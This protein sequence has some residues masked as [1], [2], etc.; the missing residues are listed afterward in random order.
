M[1]A[2]PH[3]TEGAESPVDP[4]GT[5][6]PGETAIFF[7]CL[8]VLTAASLWPLWT[9]RFLPMQDYPQ[10]L[11]LAHVTST[12]DH[13]SFNWKEFY[14]VDVGFRPYMLWY[15]AMDLLSKVLTAEIAGRILFSLYILLLALLA[16]FARRLAPKGFLPWGALLLFPF[17]FNQ[18]YYMGFSNYIISLPILFLALLDLD[19]LAENASACDIARHLMYCVLLFLTHPYTVLVYISLAATSAMVSR[20]TRYQSLR[21][22]IPPGAMSLIFA[23]WYLVQHGPSSAPAG[24]PWMVRWWPPNLSLTYYLLQFTGMRWTGGPDWIT[25]G[26][27]SLVALL[28]GV[29]WRRCDRNNAILRRLVA[30][31]FASLV[32]FMSLPFWMG[33]YAYFNLRMAPVSYFALS[34][35]LC[36]IPVPS[37]C[38]MVLAC[39]ILALVAGSVQTQKSVARETETILPVLGAARANA[40][41]LSLIFDGAS[42]VIDPVSFYQMHAH[43]PDYYHLLVGG[44]A[45]P[46][47]FPNAM[48]P[49]QYQPG[50]RLPYPETVADFTW[51]DHGAYYDYV[52]L[53]AAPQELYQDLAVTCDLVAKAGSWGL[54]RNKTARKPL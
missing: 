42:E 15:I 52:L 1:P 3:A 34:L 21:M 54:F 45:S 17:A 23:T 37:R 47:L 48:L 19:R 26:L 6:S 51:T 14:R 44:G 40:L 31:Y 5:A 38:G 11:F 29:A 16:L 32:G 24:L 22:L 46:D 50:L 10:H 41:M 20:S 43:E 13:P 27:W 39:S 35:L 7:C 25:V 8:F 49:V 28:F 30:L 9:T 18:M 2:T 33:Y 4:D 12:Y 36:R 53:R